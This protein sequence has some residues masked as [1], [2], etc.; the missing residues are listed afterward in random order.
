MQK[1]R[2]ISKI[3]EIKVV[4]ICYICYHCGRLLRCFQPIHFIT[5]YYFH[6]HFYISFVRYNDVLS[7]AAFRAFQTGNIPG[8]K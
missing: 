8:T 3:M 6:F 7:R 2:K 4:L 1:E 5:I